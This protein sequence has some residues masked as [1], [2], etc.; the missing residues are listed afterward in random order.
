VSEAEEPSTP[1]SEESRLRPPAPCKPP[2]SLTAGPGSS[3]GE[4][5]EGASEKEKGPL[6]PLDSTL[7]RREPAVGAAL[8]AGHNGGWK[9][10]ERGRLC[11][12]MLLAF[13][14]GDGSGSL[15]RWRFSDA[16]KRVGPTAVFSLF[17]NAEGGSPGDSLKAQ[18]QPR[19][20]RGNFTWGYNC[21]FDV[22]DYGNCVDRIDINNPQYSSCQ[23]Q[24]G[25]R[26][27]PIYVILNFH[28]YKLANFHHYMHFLILGKTA[29]PHLH[30]RGFFIYLPTN[31]FVSV[32]HLQ[33][34]HSFFHILV[35]SSL[36]Y[37]PCFLVP[38]DLCRR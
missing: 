23:L 3:I 35:S 2:P 4:A 12:G 14:W 38:T 20:K 24:L 25:S 32:N 31:I 16:P 13:F 7:R 28:Q 10:M 6:D 33:V 27:L 30:L 19:F 37:I 11:S 8:A 21:C 17:P 5:P 22:M 29:K 36:A 18:Q 26:T 1:T 9:T 15:W 34:L